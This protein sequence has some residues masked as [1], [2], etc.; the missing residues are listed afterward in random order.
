MTRKDLMEILKRRDYG[1]KPWVFPQPV[2]MIGTY[3]DAGEP[4]LM[5]AVWGGQYGPDKIILC[6]G[7]HKTTENIR[8]RKAFTVSFPCTVTACACDYV[9]IVS[10]NDEPDKMLKG[11]F[12]SHKSE[13]VDAPIIH[14]LML[15]MECKLVKFNEDGYVIGEIVNVAADKLIMSGDEIDRKL[16]RPIVYDP[17]HNEYVS[18]GEEVGKAFSLGEKLKK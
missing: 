7:E 17:I 12:S 2:M 18:L 13:L 6:L 16:M 4:N 9:G 14:E 15:S 5:T 3:D 10:A 8:K 1:P 11:G